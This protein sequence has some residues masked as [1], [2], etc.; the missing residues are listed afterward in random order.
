MNNP[1]TALALFTRIP[2]GRLNTW[3]RYTAAWLW[4]PGILGGIV[5]YLA[6]QLFGSTDIGMIAAVGGEAILTGGVHWRGFVKIFDAWTAKP[7]ERSQIRRQ[8]GAGAVGIL[9]VVLALMALAALWKHGGALVPIVWIMPPLWA[10]ALAAW[11]ST[12]RR[13]DDSSA[14]MARLARETHLGSGAWIT[15]VIAL[16]L[17]AVSLGFQAVDVFGGSLIIVGLFLWWG[18]RLF[19]GMNEELF[20]ASVILTEIVALYLIII[21]TPVALF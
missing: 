4:L 5:W 20:F 16:A 2:V 13:V 12:W 17:G 11:A 21:F 9:F 14:W 3:G 1:R 10:R 7:I 19:R 6:F 15:L 8:W 18:V